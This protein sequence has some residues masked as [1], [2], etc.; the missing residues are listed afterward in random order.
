MVNIFP[1]HQQ[2]EYP[3]FERFNA[4]YGGILAEYCQLLN[5]CQIDIL[6]VEEFRN[7]PGELPMIEIDDKDAFTCS[8]DLQHNDA[9]FT[10][11]GIIFNQACI[12]ALGLTEEEQYA[13]IAHEI[14]HIIYRCRMLNSLIINELRGTWFKCGSSFSV[15][16]ST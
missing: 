5:A 15:I 7:E 4:I 1:I 2:Q 14:G 8:S 6:T 3:I 16:T 10:K 13:A 11:A 12:D 9:S